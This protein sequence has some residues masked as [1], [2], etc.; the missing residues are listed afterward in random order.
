MSGIVTQMDGWR[1]AGRGAGGR[2]RRAGARLATSLGLMAPRVPER[3]LIAPQ[4]I[5]TNDPTIATDIY[6][7][8]LAFA[9]RVLST[10]GVSPFSMEPPSAA[11]GVE[12]HG[13][14]WLRHLRAADTHLSRANGRAL[15]GDW[16]DQTGDKPRGIAA[17]PAV[18]ARRLISWLTQSPLLLEGSNAV[19]Y[20][21]FVRS[22]ARMAYRL[23]LELPAMP[24]TADRLLVLCA[25]NYYG[26]CASGT[27][28]LLRRHARLLVDDLE[29]QILS[30]GGHVSRNPA[31][32]VD[33]LLDL[34]PLR[35]AFTHRRLPPPQE[36][37]NAVD[38]MLPM[39]RMMRHGDGALALF[40]G[41]STTQF[42]HVAAVLAYDDTR[43]A[44]VEHAPYSGY[45]RIQAE[46]SLLIVDT[47]PPPAA[48]RSTDAH[49]GCLSFELSAGLQ[50]LVV[51]CGAAPGYW[52]DL[53]RASRATAAHS[54]VTVADTS[55]C[56]FV[57]MRGAGGAD[58]V[59]IASGPTEVSLDR[60]VTDDE[61]LLL[62]SHDGY[63]QS[64]GLI[65]T[66]LLA[67][68][69]NG[70]WLRGE[71]RVAPA[72]ARRREPS[73]APFAIRFH[74]HPSVRPTQ[75]TDGSVELTASSGETWRFTAE[76]ADATVEESGFFAVPGGQRAT[77]QIVL[78][79]DSVALPDIRWRFERIAAGRT[80][81]KP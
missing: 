46:G 29:E 37:S 47:G 55:S 75:N 68:A 71:D 80:R 10:H 26:L 4:D 40:N 64:F 34:L 53:R 36:L 15:V 63:A 13:F 27:D 62:A 2:L 59:E 81:Q 42:D 3:L 44:P 14:G 20:H 38:R 74:L 67:L 54:T 5:R 1:G 31:V 72:A 35:Q 76:N 48:A 70:A 58:V 69:R 57:A 77:T 45:Q 49:G 41:M 56:R 22:L 16:I 52:P 11:F 30:D 17:A 7:G 51:N 12:L 23:M 28:A 25:L 32:L 24:S 39:L 79:G 50:R 60:K 9:G 21:R 33:L 65:H 61:I 8:H 19:F 78:N 6:A 43:A 18:E 73:P 66:R